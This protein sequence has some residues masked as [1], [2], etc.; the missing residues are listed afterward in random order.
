MLQ[1]HEPD[2][3]RVDVDGARHYRI[4]DRAGLVP[5]VTTVLA[6]TWGE[7]TWGMKVWRDRLEAL[8]PG[9]SVLARD[10]AA[11]RGDR[12]HARMTRVLVERCMP[13]R[14]ELAGDGWLRSLEPVMRQWLVI[15]EVML[16]EGMVWHGFDGY[17]G[18][19]DFMLKMLGP[20]LWDLKSHLSERTREQLSRGV[21]QLGGYVEAFR[22]TYDMDV[23]GC[24]LLVALP[25]RPAQVVI[26][27]PQEAVEAW[28]R[29][30]ESYRLHVRNGRTTPA[31]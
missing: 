2:P 5:S 23:R 15:A 1:R 11:A 6:H 4:P 19:L 29:R 20:R 14:A 8:Q 25:D 30:F 12:L 24:G 16:A 3:M 31:R 7:E 17:A 21:A 9:L 13:E 22:W 18:T 10:V 28:A 26:V 27:K